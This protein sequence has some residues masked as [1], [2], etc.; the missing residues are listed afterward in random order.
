MNH[1]E[2]E[3]IKILREEW[4]E[5]YYTYF[6][7]KIKKEKNIQNDDTEIAE[8]T[9][10]HMHCLMRGILPKRIIYK[11]TEL[12]VK[13]FALICVQ[14]NMY[15][16]DI[17]YFCNLDVYGYGDI[18]YFFRNEISLNPNLTVDIIEKN[19]NLN[20]NFCNLSKNI[21]LNYFKSEIIM[22]K[23]NKLTNQECYKYLSE[24]IFLT[25]RYVLENLDKPWYWN[26]LRKNENISIDYLTRNK[27]KNFSFNPIKLNNFINNSTAVV[28]IDEFIE[29]QYNH[30]KSF[31]QLKDKFDKSTDKKLFFKKLEL[32]RKTSKFLIKKLADYYDKTN[33]VIVDKN[34]IIKETSGN[35]SRSKNLTLEIIEKNPKFDWDYNE[36]SVFKNLFKKDDLF[37]NLMK[38]SKIDNC[39][40]FIEYV[41]SNKFFPL[42]CV[43]KNPLSKK[44]K[45]PGFYHFFSTN[46]Y[47]KIFRFLDFYID[48][49]MKEYN[50]KIY[51]NNMKEIKF[52]IETIFLHPDNISYSQKELGYECFDMLKLFN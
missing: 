5:N 38:I 49:K 23:F 36:F 37:N 22:K 43:N 34:N 28:V 41:N 33:Y 31:E 15:F 19:I 45:V 27:K 13:N 35:I 14:K 50:F 17:M 21:F 12:T 8:K 46:E 32:N 3:K 11:Y 10:M 2:T 9:Y 18:F 47:E 25:N 26:V 24:N 20:W 4:I 40:N 48:Y 44:P 7:Q 42:I 6:Y 16:E 52:E 30:W 29:A 51:K 1:R 39:N